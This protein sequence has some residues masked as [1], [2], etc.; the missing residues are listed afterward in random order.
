MFVLRAKILPSLVQS[1]NNFRLCFSQHFATNFIMLFLGVLFCLD[2]KDSLSCKLCIALK[3]LEIYLD[4][5]I[6]N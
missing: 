6:F 5:T 3:M 4:E 2:K 1:G